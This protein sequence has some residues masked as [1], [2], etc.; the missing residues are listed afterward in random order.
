MKIFSINDFW[1]SLVG[2]QTTDE[3]V[4]TAARRE[5]IKK[6]PD[7]ETSQILGEDSSVLFSNRLLYDKDSHD[8]IVKKIEDVK[9]ILNSKFDATGVGKRFASL[10]EAAEKLKSPSPAS[11]EKK[12]KI[13]KPAGTGMSDAELEALLA[14]QESEAAAEKATKGKPSPAPSNAKFDL[15]AT[16][17]KLA[18]LIDRFLDETKLYIKDVFIAEIEKAISSADRYRGE[19]LGQVYRRIFIPQHNQA[20]GKYEATYVQIAEIMGNEKLRESVGST[21]EFKELSKVFKTIPELNK[22]D[23]NSAPNAGVDILESTLGID[24]IAKDIFKN[25]ADIVK[26]KGNL[27]AKIGKFVLSESSDGKFI[28]NNESVNPDDLGSRY[29]QFIALLIKAGLSDKVVKYFESFESRDDAAA[30][31]VKYICV[32]FMGMLSGDMK[33]MGIA[34]IYSIIDREFQGTEFIALFKSVVK[35]L[36]MFTPSIESI[37]REVV[38]VDNNASIQI[39]ESNGEYFVTLIYGDLPPKRFSLESIGQRGYSNYILKALSTNRSEALQELYKK[40]LTVQ[41]R[42]EIYSGTAKDPKDSKYKD[43]KYFNQIVSELG[44]SGP[45]GGGL[46]PK[47]QRRIW[48]I[49]VASFTANEGHP[50]F[51]DDPLSR[52][53]ISVNYNNTISLFVEFSRLSDHTF[54]ISRVDL[55]HADTGDRQIASKIVN[56]LTNKNGAYDFDVNQ[57]RN[58][59]DINERKRREIYNKITMYYVN[60]LSS[61]ES[62]INKTL[63]PNVTPNVSPSATTVVPETKTVQVKK[64]SKEELE[65][66]VN[67]FNDLNEK[68]KRTP[69]EEK[70][71][72]DLS[73]VVSD[74]ISDIKQMLDLYSDED[75]TLLEDVEKTTKTMPKYEQ[76]KL[77]RRLDSLYESLDNK[78]TPQS[79]AKKIQVEIDSITKKL[80]EKGDFSDYRNINDGIDKI[81]EDLLDISIHD[82]DAADKTKRAAIILLKNSPMRDEYKANARHNLDKYPALRGYLENTY[83]P[84]FVRLVYEN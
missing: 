9:K 68:T 45:S 44:G 80:I 20:R 63:T 32:H 37:E 12:V 36:E 19:T 62:T 55:A 17:T 65:Q 10:K 11:K 8:A 33:K 27:S 53:T 56:A 48:D 4:V 72:A 59:G 70:R 15:S 41:I 28:I 29:E 35:N 30:E 54:K 50:A 78:K 52:F 46:S 26:S 57:Y 83:S 49:K 40:L 84:E 22:V 51:N 75:D 1:S 82:V 73:K 7:E 21:P 39:F 81:E 69:A 76:N 38:R 31:L 71:L 60:F 3:K 34:N 13:E 42:N 14:M 74:N 77:M 6:D 47:G 16:T 25:I 66:I 58:L 23:K 61:L 2:D 79:E 24:A 64:Y 5:P 18:E 43:S 67:E